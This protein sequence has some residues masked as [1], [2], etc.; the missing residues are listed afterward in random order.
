MVDPMRVIER[1]RRTD[2]RLKNMTREDIR[3][4]IH[5]HEDHIADLEAEVERLRTEVKRLRARIRPED[6]LEVGE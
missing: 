1:E 4:E 2:T 3:D 5:G 6:A